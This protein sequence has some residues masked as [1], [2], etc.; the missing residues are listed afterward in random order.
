[1]RAFSNLLALA[2]AV[3][4]AQAYWK[5]FNIGA[6]KADGSCK[7]QQ[8]WESDFRTQQGLTGHFSSARL[9]ASSDCNTLANAVPAAITTGTGLLV[10]VWT[11]DQAHYNA[12]KAALLQA[13]QQHGHDW[14]I[15]VSVGSEDLYRGDTSASTLAGQI[16][17]IR[18]SLKSAGVTGVEV[19]H[20]DTWTAWVD[21]ANTD[22]IKACD[23][24][25][26]DGYPYFQNA[27]IND[28]YNV[29][30]ESVQNVRD[31]VN[32]VSPGKWVWIT[33]SGWPVSGPNSGAAVP[34]T[35]NAQKYWSTVACAA[36]EQAHTFWYTL[37]DTNA[38]PS[39]GV[40]D[41]NNKPIYNLA[42]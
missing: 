24:I 23:F 12:E 9:Y 41:T 30:W 13:V 39:F 16:N 20:V 27:N 38:S 40:V 10:G 34:S 25:G 5:G 7:S 33:E 11:E 28:G 2:A 6:N 4:G 35:A 31:T 42:C 32:K 22:V 37:S 21:G 26:T 3:S 8:D 15:A 17:D 29:F 14:L 36:F 19:G 1:M 18:N